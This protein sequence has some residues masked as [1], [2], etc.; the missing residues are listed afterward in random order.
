MNQV[1]EDLLLKGWL[2]TYLNLAEVGLEGLRQVAPGA[3]LVGPSPAGQGWSCLLA[4]EGTGS[5]G[6]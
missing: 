1:N 2:L 4:E 3:A 6:V 5:G